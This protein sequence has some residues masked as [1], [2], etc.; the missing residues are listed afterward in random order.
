MDQFIDGIVNWLTNTGLNIGIRIIFA[1]IALIISFK[2]INVIASKIEKSGDKEKYDKTIMRTLA[3]IFKI[4]AKCII[5]VCLI[6]FLGI[7]TSGIT[8]LIASLGVCFGL[9][10]NGAVANIAGGVLLIITRPFKIDDFIEAQGYSG[11]VEAIHMTNTKVRTP[12]NKVV[13]IPNGPLSNGNIVNYSIKPTRRLDLTFSISYDAD[14]EKAK[15]IIADICDS[16]ELILKDPE[17]AIR[18]GAHG[19][20]AID[21]GTKVWVNGGDYWTVNFD[22]LESVKLA[23][24]K[25]GIEVPYNQLDVHIKEAK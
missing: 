24:D 17:P 19:D 14:F 22:L 11:T 13:F 16:H 8:A 18:V 12:D 7:D 21:I 4:G 6:G 5:A 2:I 25:E 3:Y 20:H 1:V 15:A 10:V 9:A 23:F